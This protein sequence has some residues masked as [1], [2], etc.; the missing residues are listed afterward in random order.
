MNKTI[1]M[2]LPNIG[3]DPTESAVP[4]RIL[5]SN[6]ASLRFATEVG[7]PGQCDPRMLKGYG[8]GPL[9]PLLAA[10]KNGL[11]SY[12]RMVQSAEF[13]NPLA[14][15]QI[16]VTDFDGIIL[17]GGHAPGMKPYLESKFLQDRIAEFF[18]AGKP[19]GAICH[20]VV[21]AARSKTHEVS[22]LHRRK[23]TALLAVQEISAWLL[24]C[25]WLGRYYRTYPQT[26]ESEVKSVLSDDSNFVRG[27]MALL[28][29]NPEN[30]NRGFIVRDGNYLSARWP[31]DAHRFAYEFLR[32][33][34]I[35][36]LN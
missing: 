24:T 3:F 19:V 13:Q 7:L 10:D 33:L 16:A 14:W 29:D 36:P 22:V 11:E 34:S 30:L 25:A 28:R 20:G 35:Y 12:H 27:P 1:I 23:T 31:G 8:L 2:P 9:A 6:G 4:W 32:M 5:S 18:L 15:E 21:L 17:P 26:V